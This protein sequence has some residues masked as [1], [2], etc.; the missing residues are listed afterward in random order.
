MKLICLLK[1]GSK[2]VY[3]LL[4]IKVDFGKK[5]STGNYLIISRFDL[6]LLE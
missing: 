5:K 1:N 3:C 6:F 2:P 4:H